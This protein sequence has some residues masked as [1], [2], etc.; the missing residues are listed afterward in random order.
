MFPPTQAAKNRLLITLV[1]DTSDSMKAGDAITGLNRSLREWREELLRR[2]SIQRIAEIALITFGDGGVRVVDA[3]GGAVAEPYVTVDKFNPPELTAGGYSPMVP[4][5]RRALAIA[6]ER[7]A[8][9]DSAG[10]GMAYRRLV[11]LITDGA[12]SDDRGNDDDSWRDLAPELRRREQEP[13]F[14]GIQFTCFAVQGADRDVLRA[15]APDALY[16][17]GRA[18][19]A[20]VLNR[21]MQSIETSMNKRKDSVSETLKE[22]S[23]QDKRAQE[24]HDWFRAQ[25]EK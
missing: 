9:L 16:D 15:L 8:A 21:V 20:T 23:R 13:G 14:G 17:I 5:I 2:P 6:D 24:M 18:N 10:I 19:F 25:Q 3:S 7:R 22:V 11:Y 4:A 12:P 1:L